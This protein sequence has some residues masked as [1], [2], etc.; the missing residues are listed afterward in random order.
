MSGCHPLSTS[1]AKLGS[2]AL[3]IGR[4]LCL[5]ARMDET[6]YPLE[7]SDRERVRLTSQAAILRPY[8]ERLLRSAGAREGASVLDLGTGAGDVALLAAEIVGASGRVVSID[9]D[10]D[11]VTHARKRATDAGLNNVTFAQGDINAPPTDAPF[12]LAVG[13]YVLMYQKDP[14]ATVRAVANAVRA[15]GAVGFH[16]LN[17]YEGVRGDMWP[18]S[19]AGQGDAMQSMGPGLFARVQNHM[20]VRLPEVFAAAGLDI[21]DWGFEGAA[22]IS[23]LTAR[24]ESMLRVLEAARK[25]SREATGVEDPKLD[26]FER[27]WRDAPPYAAMLQPPAVLGWARKP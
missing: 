1:T 26:A 11:H 17:M 27:W 7:R 10:A 21:S 15:G 23:P 19:P 25:R 14:V 18:E 24:K 16:E 2:I 22:P 9:I 20:G 13:R 12:D 3:R 6:D 8:T 4:L 5:Y